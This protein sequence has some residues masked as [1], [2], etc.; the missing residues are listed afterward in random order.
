MDAAGATLR[1]QSLLQSV[2]VSVLCCVFAS[3]LSHRET[4]CL[5]V[6]GWHCCMRQE[7]AVWSVKQ[8]DKQT[9]CRKKDWRNKH[10]VW[11]DCVCEWECV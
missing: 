11:W 6:K 9:L 7:A 8:E 1:R 2:L 4:C 3:V 10:V 5:N